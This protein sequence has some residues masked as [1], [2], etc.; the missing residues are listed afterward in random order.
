MPI[1]SIEIQKENIDSKINAHVEELNRLIEKYNQKKGLEDL[2]NLEHQ[3]KGLW[4]KF[5]N[6]SRDIPRSQLPLI[7]WIAQDHVNL[8]IKRLQEG[9]LV[10]TK[11][12]YLHEHLSPELMG[13]K[14]LKKIQ[15]RSYFGLFSKYS[16]INEI[17]IVLNTPAD[18][19]PLE[20]VELYLNNLLEF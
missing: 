13:Y 6:E 4:K 16:P 10:Y 18:N 17:E 2:L 7:R 5:L 8:E 12:K 3:R 14:N 19:D 15:V 20:A 11:E 1:P 9:E